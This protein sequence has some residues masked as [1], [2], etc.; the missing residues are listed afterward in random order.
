M[1]SQFHKPVLLKEV[2][3]NLNIKPNKT[4]LD[5]TFGGGGH[6]RAILNANPKCK[7]VAMDWDKKTIDQNAPALKEEFGDRFNILWGNFAHIK[8]ILEKE[9][10]EKLGGI[11]ADFGTSQH[12]IQQTPGIS[13]Y[14]DTPLDMRISKSHHYFKASDIVN[15]FREKELANIFF[16][17]G[18]EKQSRKIAKAIVEHRKKEKIETSRQLAEIIEAIIPK[19]KSPRRKF[20]IHPATK[21]FQALR[22][23]VNK[24]LENIEIFL[25]DAVS[26]LNPGGRIACIS[27]HS[28]EDRIVKNFFRDN[29][30]EL[31]ILTKKPIIATQEEVAANPSSRSAKLRVAEKK[32]LKLINNVDK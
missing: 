21:V 26:F 30:Q 6:T 31:E 25:K 2:I 29:K 8:R 16:E 18:E 27:F 24:E 19:Y 13:F 28:L 11:L 20:F 1:N 17:L 7:V 12:Q 10:I 23:F 32:E 3:E 14:K 5:V 9:K 15:R 22:I 4:Y